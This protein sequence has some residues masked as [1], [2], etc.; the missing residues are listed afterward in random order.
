M[1][2]IRAITNDEDILLDEDVEKFLTELMELSD[3][4][5]LDEDSWARIEKRVEGRELA[6]YRFL[7][8]ASNLMGT[9]KFLELAREGKSIPS[10][11][12]KAYLPAL[13]IFDDIVRAGPSFLQVLRVLHKR[14]QKVNK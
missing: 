9:K 2:F 1:D 8:G 12:V 7:V 10:P 5:L 14:A 3:E 11:Y 6:L 13:E 4:E